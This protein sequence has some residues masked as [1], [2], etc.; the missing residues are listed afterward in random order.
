MVRIAPPHPD[1]PLYALAEISVRPAPILPNGGGHRDGA[2]FLPQRSGTT[3]ARY[4]NQ[5]RTYFPTGVR[6]FRKRGE[7][8]VSSPYPRPC[9]LLRAVSLI[10]MNS[11]G[12]VPQHLTGR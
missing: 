5:N 12:H 8:S 3:C 6:V 7:R 4:R 10:V 1:E 2:A 11:G 9:R